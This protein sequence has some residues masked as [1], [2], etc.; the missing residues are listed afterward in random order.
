[1]SIPENDDSTPETPAKPPK[2]GRQGNARK[3]RTKGYNGQ[4][5][6]A[7]QIE[8]RKDPVILD[9][10]RA[11]E[12]PWREQWPPQECLNAVN[13]YVAMKY[14]DEPPIG[15]D[16]MYLDRGRL[17]EMR[18]DA[19]IVAANEISADILGEYEFALRAAW[20]RFR[21]TSATSLNSSG[22]LNTI[23]NLIEKKAKLLGKLKTSGDATAKV[24]MEDREVE[25]TFVLNESD[26]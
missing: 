16:T 7:H 18:T 2:R 9:R 15:I 20:E 26:H 1:M 25:I 12:T 24:S 3:G 19:A 6:G 8:W 10:I 21:A 23:S 11:G 4:K 13:A 17:M 22:L 5:G 14:P